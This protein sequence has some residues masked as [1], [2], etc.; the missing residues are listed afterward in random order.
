M[1]M[2]ENIGFFTRPPA[3][4][5]VWLKACHSNIGISVLLLTTILR[6]LL[7]VFWKKMYE[8]YQVQASNF[9]YLYTP[10]GD[11]KFSPIIFCTRDECTVRPESGGP[12][13]IKVV[14]AHWLCLFF[15][16]PCMFTLFIRPSNWLYKQI[17]N[18]V[19]M[20]FCLSDRLML[21]MKLTYH[22]FPPQGIQP[23]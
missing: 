22:A 15:G 10:I 4:L 23:S 16:T 6:C 17:N 13:L 5:N 3:E 8:I 19:L 9:T 11:L 1:V 21:L 12:V 18:S 2:W 7:A 20:R 14:F